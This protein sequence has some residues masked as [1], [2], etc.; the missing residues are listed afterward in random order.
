MNIFLKKYKN[1]IFFV[2]IVMIIGII[3]WVGVMLNKNPGE[4]ARVR[5]D[6]ETYGTYPLSQEGRYIIKG[7]SGDDVLEIKDGGARIVEAQ[8]PDGLCVDMGWIFASGESVIC[9]PNR[10]VVE[11][12]AEDSEIDVLVK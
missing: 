8:C 2:F 12:V 1:D 5:V 9:L 7:T 6:G 3:L 4:Y 10:I 11:I